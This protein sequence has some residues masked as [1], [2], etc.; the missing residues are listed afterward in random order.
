MLEIL[1]SNGRIDSSV[2]KVIGISEK[3]KIKS[4]FLNDEE[5]LLLAKKASLDGFCGKAGSS[6]EIVSKRGKVIAL[7]LG[8]NS[9]ELDLQS[10]GGY[11][12]SKLFKD[13]TAVVYIDKLKLT[14]FSKEDAIHNLAFG[15]LL[16]SY[17]FDK[18]FTTKKAE[19]YPNLEKIIFRVENPDV[20]NEGFKKY[21]ALA[22]AVRYGRDLCNEPANYL[23]PEVFAADIKRLEYLGLEVEILGQKEL[24]EKGFGCLLAVAKGSKQES[25]VA[26]VKWM[27]N[28]KTEAWD[29]AL[30]GKGV[31]FD[32][33]GIS[34]KPSSGMEDMKQDMTGAAVVVA[35]LKALALQCATK[36]VIGIVGLVENMP[37]GEATRPGDV[38][39][40]MSGQTVEVINTD[41]EGR[42]VLAD[43]LWYVQQKY[44]VKKIVD[45]ATLTGATM[46]ALGDEYAGIFAN[47]DK[48][49]NS[50]IYSGEISGEKLWRMPLGEG[51]NK[52]INSDIA[53]MKN[54]GGALAGGSTAACFLQRFIQKGVQW[55]HLDIAGVDKETKGSA[56]CPKGATAFGIRLL[57][58][59][60]NA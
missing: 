29:L 50:L 27:G 7:G 43:C 23:T 28:N 1:F 31:T 44:G 41:A 21:A 26:I 19:D 32:S 57:N 20:V 42:L 30:V 15:V 14:K 18:Y 40:S 25:K 5:N 9:T 24:E 39:T 54:I 38:V 59:F 2:V 12:V 11:L 17:R 45:I 13:E 33:G 4:A 47:N 22:N 52:K 49:A 16:G 8:K 37:S 55:S 6:V 58:Y 60:I 10:A 36:N 3:T 34:I 56:L 46:R 53:D 48:F 51:Y 35:S